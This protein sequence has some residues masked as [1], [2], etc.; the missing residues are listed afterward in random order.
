MS[1]A[2]QKVTDKIPGRRWGAKVAVALVVVVVVLVVGVFSTSE[3]STGPNEIAVHI[4]GGPV[5]DAKFKGCV[6]ASTHQNFNSPGDVYVNYSSA[7]RDWDAT[8]QDR[9]DAAPFKVVSSDNVEMQVPIIVRFYQIT[10][11][12]TLE[13]FYSNLGQRYGAF[14]EADGSGSAGWETMIRKIVADPVDV[15]LGRITQKYTWTTVRNDPKVRTEIASTLRTGIVELVDSNAQGHYFDHFSV[16][17]KKPEPTDPNLIKKINDAQAATYAAEAA[18]KTAIA[19]KAQAEAQQQ[20]A[21]AEAQKKVAEILGYK[22]PGMTNSQAVRAFNEH[23]LI[24][25]GGNPYQPQGQMLLNGAAG[26]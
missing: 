4:G 18:Q 26:R 10:D 20:V 14:I 25:K 7:Q 11:C 23:Y 22:L 12:R 9:A 17:V 13:K 16:L 5:E 15:E 2:Y 3:V 1:N 8:G 24:E 6:P 19:Q 21:K